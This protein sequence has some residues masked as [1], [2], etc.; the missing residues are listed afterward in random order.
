M[1]TTVSS[2]TCRVDGCARPRE[3]KSN[4]GY[5]SLCCGH[6][7]RLKRH[8]DLQVHLPLG[9]LRNESDTCQVAGCE[10]PRKKVSSSTGAYHHSLCSAHVARLARHGDVLADV[11]VREGRRQN[12]SGSYDVNGYLKIKAPSHPLAPGTGYVPMHRIVLY[13]KIGPGEHPCH[14]CG[15][16]VSW[17][18]RP[19]MLGALETDHLNSVRD[20]NSPG[21][22]VPS[23][24]PCNAGRAN[25]SR[26]GVS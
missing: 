21:N 26:V 15:G 24:R 6:R 3:K 12:G 16:T 25:A 22:L 23:C 20:D 4:G 11:P 14:W 18:I 7:S 8:G 5:G 2:D 17:E 19:P 9:Y 10:R 1:P 13:G